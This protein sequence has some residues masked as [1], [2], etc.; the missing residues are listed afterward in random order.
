MMGHFKG[1]FY[2]KFMKR[3]MDVVLSLVAIIVLCPLILLLALLVRNKLGSP[4]FFKQQRP[5]LHE[6]IFMMYKFRTMTDERDGNGELLPDA[7]RL[8]RFG[9]FLRSTS[10]DE[11]PELFNILKGDMSIVGPRPL[12]V[13]YLTLYND[14]QKRRHEVRPGLSGL[15]QISGRNAIGWEDKFDL[16]VQYIDNISFIED[17]KIIFLTIKKVFV[18]EGI[19]SETAVTMEPFKG[20]SRERVNI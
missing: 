17:W 9:K 13:Q 12:L 16:D 14:H 3:P 4:V 19:H 7:V 11:L 1:G 20:T 8:T 6:K 15:A 10:L 5:G 2:Q 18:R